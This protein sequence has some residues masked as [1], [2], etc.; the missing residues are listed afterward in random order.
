MDVQAAIDDTE[1]PAGVDTTLGGAAEA[2]SDSFGALGITMLVAVAL[3][4]LTMVATFVSLLT[5][6]V[7]LLT[8]QL[9]AIGAFPVLL[10]TGRELGLPAMLGL[11]PLIGIVV[12]HA[13]AMHEFVQLP[14]E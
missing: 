8:L 9:A 14:Q 3:V 12:N 1:L 10:V 13:L 11:L 7:I 4:Y 2:Q 5:P 6:F